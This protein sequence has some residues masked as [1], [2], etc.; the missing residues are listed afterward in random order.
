MRRGTRERVVIDGYDA[1]ALLV[2]TGITPAQCRSAALTIAQNARDSGDLRNLL[3]ATGL[4]R[5]PGR[6]PRPVCQ[7]PPGRS[8]P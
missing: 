4:L 8:P 6:K 3:H 5:G 1:S 2:L 7:A